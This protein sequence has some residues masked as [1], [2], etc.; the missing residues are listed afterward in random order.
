SGA[1]RRLTVLPGAGA[2]WLW[3]PRDARGLVEALGPVLAGHPDVRVAV[4]RPGDDLEGFR[5]SHLDA[6]ATQQVLA[7]LAAPQRAAAYA[8]VH[9]VALLTQDPAAC[10]AYLRDTLGDLLTADADTRDTVLVYVREQCGTSR[11]A[12]R[13]YTHR[14]TVVRRLARADELLPRPLASNVVEVAAA[15]EVLRWRGLPLPGSDPA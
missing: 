14:N 12:E 4:G 11:A 8:D 10:D 2:L 6:V 1:A 5:R 15:L 3:L 13:L 9:L 7:R